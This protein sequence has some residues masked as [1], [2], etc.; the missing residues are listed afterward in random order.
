MDSQAHCVV[1]N[2]KSMQNYKNQ[3]GF[4]EWFPTSIP[5]TRAYFWQKLQQEK[6]RLSNEQ[7]ND[8]PCFYFKFT[9][10]RLCTRAAEL[11]IY[12]YWS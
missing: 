6:K 7:G 1:V 3:M 10:F 4:N 2:Y 12:A 11:E 8:I 9:V 5:I